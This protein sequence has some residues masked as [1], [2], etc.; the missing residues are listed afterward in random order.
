LAQGTYFI[1]GS[2]VKHED[3]HF[4]IGVLQLFDMVPRIFQNLQRLFAN[5]EID[6]DCGGSLIVERGILKHLLMGREIEPL[7]KGGNTKGSVDVE[8]A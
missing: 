4:A 3:L 6:I 1:L 8:L 2:I 7:P 5:G